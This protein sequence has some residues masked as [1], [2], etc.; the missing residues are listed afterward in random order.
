MIRD[1][2]EFLL[3][4]ETEPVGP[5]YVAV[6]D[7]NSYSKGRT[8]D[9]TRVPVF[10]RTT[11]RVLRGAREEAYTF[12][13]ILNDDDP[14]QQALRQAE[15][16]DVPVTIRVTSDGVNGFTQSVRV[17]SFTH[18][19]DPDGFQEITFEMAA[20]DAPVVAGTGGGLLPGP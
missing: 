9:V 11:P 6:E 15:D 7:M 18:D 4:V 17:S 14:G 12:S 8:R 10:N 5:T 19:A 20:E 16:D 13:G 3:E 2:S 1:G